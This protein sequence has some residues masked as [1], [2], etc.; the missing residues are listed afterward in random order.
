MK[1]LHVLD[2]SVPMHSGYSFRTLGILRHQRAR[3]WQ[4][5]HLT[6]PKHTHP[7]PL[8]EE[9]EG[10][11]FHRTPSPR[12][13]GLDGWPVL[14]EWALMRATE[15]R[16]IEVMRNERPDILHAHSPALNAVPA[17]RVG[18]RFGVPVV[19][20]IRAFWEDAAA[21]HGTARAGDWRYRLTR[22]LETWAVRHADAVTTIAEGLRDDLVAR[23]VPA[24]KITVI[25][26]AVDASTFHSSGAR[27]PDLEAR[28]GLTGRIVLGFI[29]SFYGYE[30][31]D[32]LLRAVPDLLRDRPEVR[33][34]MVGGGPEEARLKALAA[35]LG[36]AEQ[37]IFT[38]RVPHVEVQGYYDLVDLLVFPRT[39]I[40]LTDLVT[41]LKP[42]EAMAMGKP[43]L[44]SDVGGHREL[45][46]DGR[47]GW[48]F[49]P[50][51]PAA[52]AA[53]VHRILVARNS[54]PSVLRAAQTMVEGE[55]SWHAVVARYEGVYGPLVPPSRRMAERR[56]SPAEA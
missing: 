56:T 32:V 40:R 42:L 14:K 20:E 11:R 49:P 31:L 7:G 27:D 22:A 54:W 17:V 35:E 2:H 44:A 6:S 38:G 24:H 15:A 37:V 16:L 47:T 55:R 48:L 36:I 10:L 1:I 4:T 8:M 51:D 25:P 50:D 19:Y 23:G 34:L 12:P 46:D 18:K 3:G 13:Q 28:L 52:L 9:A 45:I 29:G 30:G 43:V 41:P 53:A 26:N 39:R 5:S 21:S 33:V